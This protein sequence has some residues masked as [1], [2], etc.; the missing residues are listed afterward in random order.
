MSNR[1]AQMRFPI[2]RRGEERID[3]EERPGGSATSGDT[4]SMGG[5][6][7]TWQIKNEDLVEWLWRYLLLVFGIVVL[8]AGFCFWFFKAEE[9]FVKISLCLV[10]GLGICFM[11]GLSWSLALYTVLRDDEPLGND[12]ELR[13]HNLAT[14]HKQWAQL[15]FTIS[16]CVLLA[17]IVVFIIVLTIQPKQSSNEYQIA[18]Q[19]LSELF[20]EFLV[21]SVFYIVWNWSVRHFRAHWHNFIELAYRSRALDILKI[22][23]DMAAPGPDRTEF[24]KIAAELLLRYGDSAYLESEHDKTLAEK[25]VNLKDKAGEKFSGTTPPYH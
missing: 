15:W 5:Q 2:F 12:R 21:F 8:S 4:K 3:A 6:A 24:C 16:V 22:L 25:M 19:L 10:L 1:D 14:Q 13:F 9:L 11:L 17:G 7:D 20:S 23:E 18:A